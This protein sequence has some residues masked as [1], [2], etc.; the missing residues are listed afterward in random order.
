M[1]AAA[2][3]PPDRVSRALA[4]SIAEARP[5]RPGDAEDPGI[6]VAATVLV[7][8]DGARGPEVLMI[9]RPDR[10]SFA[11]AWV[12]PGGKLEPQDAVGAE[13]AAEP[14]EREEASARRAG[15]RETWE[16]VGLH[17]D[18]GVLLAVSR[19][20]PPPG[21]ALRIRTWFFAVHSPDG[22]LALSA[23]EAVSAEWV[24]PD[25]VLE[26]HGRGELTLYPPT[27]VTL[28]GLSGQ[29]DVGA[30]LD[31][32]RLRGVEHFETVARSA[33]DGPLFLWHGDAEYDQDTQAPASARHRLEAG[34]LPWRYTRDA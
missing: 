3:Q 27:W 29:G 26:R 1:P 18:P 16:E 19:W 7:L 21:I 20:D 15:T 31:V 4:D 8:R 12:F 34:A 14:V 5:R 24:R 2:P 32:L 17:L 9:E 28:H 13:A 22:A 11:G 6:P 23:D 33:A 25:D 10:G 30:L